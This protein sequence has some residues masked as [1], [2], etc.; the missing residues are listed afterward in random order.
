MKS[1]NINRR[2]ALSLAAS[3]AILPI[4]FRALAQ[5]TT[6][7]S[8]ASLLRAAITGYTVINTFDPAKVTQL[9]ESYVVWA[10]FNSLVKF[11]DKMEIVPDLAESYSFIDPTTLEF[12]LR[13]GV[14]FHDGS[15]LTSDDVKFSLERVLDE[16]RLRRTVPSFRR[17]RRS[18]RRTPTRFGS[19]RTS[20]SRRC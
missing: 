5:S 6:S 14:K 20:L 15:E 10:V 3:A 18:K 16:R 7:Q 17:S 8:S 4:S 2:Q 12:K 1:I 13:K 11:N 9:P 19:S